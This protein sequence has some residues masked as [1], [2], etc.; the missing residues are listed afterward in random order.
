[1]SKGNKSIYNEYFDYTDEYTSK[2]GEQTV[3]FLQVGAFFEIYGVKTPNDT[4]ERS[5]ITEIA[6]ICGLSISSKS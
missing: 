6:T 2:Y 4:I 3:I 5:K 1:M